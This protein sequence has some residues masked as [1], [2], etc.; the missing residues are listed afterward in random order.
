VHE[1]SAPDGD[2]GHVLLL[3]NAM[4]SIDVHN[5]P[6]SILQSPFAQASGSDFALGQEAVC[7]TMDGTEP[8]PLGPLQQQ[9]PGDRMTGFST[10]QSDYRPS[11]DGGASLFSRPSIGEGS[12]S[13]F[14]EA[15]VSTI[16]GCIVLLDCRDSK[17]SMS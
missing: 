8:L 1:K 3:A 13:G 4:T 7:I 9:A 10:A 6:A 16:Q 11:Y 2:S 14:E 5:R 12:I 15:Q 17:G